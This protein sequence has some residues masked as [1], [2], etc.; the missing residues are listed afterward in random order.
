M[1]TLS[2]QRRVYSLAAR[3]QRGFTLI[4]VM[5]AILVLAFG[6]LGFALLQTMSVRYT[7]SA[8]FRTQAT[9]LSYELL[10]QIRANR[11]IATAY[12]GSYTA[13]NAAC[14]PTVGTVTAA[15]Y[16]GAWQCRLNS[17]LGDDAT[18]EVTRNG[19]DW[20]VAITWG[21]EQRWRPGADAMTFTVST[22]L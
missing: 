21:D 17:A 11:I 10:D 2:S 15:Q 12:I 14:V 8:N 5:V 16:R 20:T 9:N 4:E 3:Q 22:T 1:K 7:Q 6:M 19:N 18:A 13:S